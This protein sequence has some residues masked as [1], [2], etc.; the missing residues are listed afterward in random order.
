MCLRQTALVRQQVFHLLINEEI[1]K[2]ASVTTSTTF[3]SLL[4]KNSKPFTKQAFSKLVLFFSVILLSRVIIHS[5]LMVVYSINVQEQYWAQW[6]GLSI[7]LSPEVQNI[8]RQE[9]QDICVVYTVVSSIFM[10]NKFDKVLRILKLMANN[11][12]NTLFQ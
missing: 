5:I 3:M 4:S 8:V 7:L 9:Q 1:C 6:H 11:L 10:S 12:I 2:C